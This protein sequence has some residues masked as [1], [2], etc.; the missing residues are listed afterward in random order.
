M[1]LALLGS[2]ATGLLAG[3]TPVTGPGATASDTVVVKA[4][5]RLVFRPDSVAI[6]VGDA[7]RWRNAGVV[8]HTATAD[9]S[10]ATLEGSVRLPDGAEPFDSGR[11]GEGE[12]FTHVFRV[13]GRY[14]YFCIPHEGAG[15]TGTVIVEE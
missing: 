15:M 8:R 11:L 14:E 9:P 12:T 13:P 6:E 2:D 5:D 10:Q 7:V 1:V 4:T 3:G